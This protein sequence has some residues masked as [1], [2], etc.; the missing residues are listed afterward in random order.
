MYVIDL[1]KPEQSDAERYLRECINGKPDDFV[2][3]GFVLVMW[4]KDRRAAVQYDAGSA[5]P[6]ECLPDFT[7]R[8]VEISMNEARED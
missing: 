5:I 8:I 4:E 2:V 7:R 1:P 3:D 6:P